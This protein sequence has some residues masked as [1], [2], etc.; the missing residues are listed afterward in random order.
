MSKIK[1]LG[2]RI[3]V[4]P[5]KAEDKTKGGLLLPEVARERPQRGT[6]IA[7]GPGT[8]LEPMTLKEGDRVLYSKHAGAQIPIKEDEDDLLIMRESDV[9]CQL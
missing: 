2:D 5:D 4:R 3:V 6:V 7:V 8:R 1:P 9:F